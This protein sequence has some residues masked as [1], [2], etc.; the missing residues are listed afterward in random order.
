MYGRSNR[1]NLNLAGY[2]NTDHQPS[3]RDASPWGKAP[4]NP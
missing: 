1:A 4:A 3:N 2:G